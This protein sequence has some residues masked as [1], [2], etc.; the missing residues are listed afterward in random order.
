MKFLYTLAIVLFSS[1]LALGAT[2]DKKDTNDYVSLKIS[3]RVMGQYTG[4]YSETSED[5]S[6]NKTYLDAYTTS[7][8]SVTR[9]KVKDLDQPDDVASLERVSDNPRVSGTG[10]GMMKEVTRRTVIEPSGRKRKAVDINRRK[11]D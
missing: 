7:Y 8:T 6:K 2:P 4:R 10:Q 9:W 5:L 11:L 1:S 3:A